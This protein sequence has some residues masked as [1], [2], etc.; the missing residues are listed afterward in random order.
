M[1]TNP[2]WL[3]PKEKPYFHQISPDCI[4]KLVKCIE[5][6]NK[7]EIGADTSLKISKQIRNGGQT[8]ICGYVFFV[9]DDFVK[10]ITSLFASGI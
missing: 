1:I 10:L 8:L 7:G 3:K 5:R 4:E 2:E 9:E 6:F